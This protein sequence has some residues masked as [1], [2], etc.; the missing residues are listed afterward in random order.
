MAQCRQITANTPLRP[1][2]GAL[3]DQPLWLPEPITNL[4]TIHGILYDGC[5]G[6]AYM[7]A[8]TYHTAANTMRQWGDEVLDYIEDDGCPVPAIA[9]GES[10][11][12]YQCALLSLAVEL[13][14]ATFNEQLDGVD[15]D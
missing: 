8:I 3:H 13:W 12:V 1:V 6:G 10:W 2:V 14:A 9:A 4:R 7:P 5:A 11:T 15:W